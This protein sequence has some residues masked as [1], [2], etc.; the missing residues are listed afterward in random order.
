[1]RPNEA[2][3][4]LEVEWDLEKGFLGRLRRGDFDSPG[5]ERLVELLERVEPNGDLPGR[6]VELT[7][8]IPIFLT[9]QEPRVSEHDGNVEQLR[10]VGT[11]ILNA[12]EKVL[13]TP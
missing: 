10:R 5:A 7:W 11:R 6:F 4:Q 9:W 2:I 1:M 12:L 13:G 8:Y 3:P